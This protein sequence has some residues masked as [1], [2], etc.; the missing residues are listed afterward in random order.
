MTLLL[1][2]SFYWTTDPHTNTDLADSNIFAG[3]LDVYIAW[4]PLPFRRVTW[5]FK[6]NTLYAWNYHLV[7]AVPEFKKDLP[8]E[9][10]ITLQLFSTGNI[11]MLSWACIVLNNPVQFDLQ[12]P[13]FSS[14][15]KISCFYL[16]LMVLKISLKF[17]WWCIL[18]YCCSS[19]L[20]GF[21][22]VL[23]QPCIICIF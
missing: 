10:F 22:L 2:D 21:F 4:I 14:F 9:L 17:L 11:C 20:W 16:I 3:G 5:A 8:V 12:F 1:Q 15:A 6:T 13:E 7:Y 19:G 23:W 18:K